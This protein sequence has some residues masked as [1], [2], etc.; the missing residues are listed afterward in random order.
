[1]KTCIN[2][3]F[4]FFAV[5]AVFSCRGEDGE[6]GEQGPPG[7]ANVIYS[8][9]FTATS[10]TSSTVFGITNL[11]YVKDAP[12]IT[13]DILDKGVVLVYGNL[14]GYVST[15]W[16]VGQVSQLPIALTYVQSG[17][18]MTDTWSAIQTVGKMTI[19]FVNDKN[20]YTSTGLATTHK[21]R[22]IIIIPGGQPIGKSSIDYSKMSYEEVCERFNIKP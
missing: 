15:V 9:W 16:P 12:Q 7:S 13:Q 21:F 14:S 11:T 8:D 2:L 17:Q 18:T 5:L 22:Y 3:I 1:M 4:M 6:K 20:L 10:Y 19:K